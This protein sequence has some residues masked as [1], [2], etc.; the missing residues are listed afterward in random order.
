MIQRKAGAPEQAEA[1]RRGRMPL[2]KR[3]KTMRWRIAVVLVALL[4]AAPQVMAQNVRVVADIP[5]QFQVGQEAR[6]AGEWTIS[7][8][9]SIAF[10]VIR[11]RHLT[12]GQ[13]M[14]AVGTP[15]YRLSNGPW[16]AKLVFNR[17]GDR[18]YLSEVWGDGGVG[19][20]LMP[21]EEERALRLAGVKLQETVIYA[22]LR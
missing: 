22:R 10:P 14:L 3:S 13:T 8:I 19:V 4:W 18:Y 21:S 17:Y 2:E 5:F 15:L 7:R 16:E 6:S 20:Y 9:D 11:L 12:N 1:E